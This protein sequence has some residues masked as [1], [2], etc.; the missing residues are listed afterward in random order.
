MTSL[1]IVR[2]AKLVYQSLRSFR[3]LHDTFFVVLSDRRAE[4]VIVHR[5]SIFPLAPQ[6][7]DF[8]R[9]LDFKNA[10]SSVDPPNARTV[11]LGIGQKFF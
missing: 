11:R 5:R 9:I 7:G 3:L 6:P 1:Q 2:M 4:L 8:D 10:F